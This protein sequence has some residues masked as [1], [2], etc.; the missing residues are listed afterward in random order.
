M[1]KDVTFD[2]K[3]SFF[4]PTYLHGESSPREDKYEEFDLF[5]LPIPATVLKKPETAAGNE[6]ENS[7]PNP[8]TSTCPNS[9]PD[10]TFGPVL[11]PPQINQPET[12]TGRPL[13][14]YTRRLQPNR[15]PLQ[16]HEFEPIQGTEISSSLPS[17]P[18][19]I[20]TD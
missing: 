8:A 3:Q 6:P 9:H 20:D 10:S 18:K 17:S 16:V 1:S 4:N 5:S 19:I 15:V 7:H 12:T 14:V 2:E 11:E 13:Q